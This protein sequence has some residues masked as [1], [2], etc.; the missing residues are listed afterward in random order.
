MNVAAL[1]D[2]VHDDSLGEA[3]AALADVSTLEERV[4]AIER[5]VVWTA[6][7]LDEHTFRLE[8]SIRR[9]EHAFDKIEEEGVSAIAR[10]LLTSRRRRR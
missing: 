5:I 6:L 9:A 7:A 10:E 4:E 8:R 2:L 3:L 1:K